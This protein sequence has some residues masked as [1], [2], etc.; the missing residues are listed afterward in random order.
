MKIQFA[1]SFFDS[2]ES[3]V[4][5]RHRWWW[6]VWDV[7]RY[8]LPNFLRNIWLFRKALWDYHWYDYRGSMQFAQTAFTD[9][10]TKVDAKGYE[11]DSTKIP[12]IVKMR[13]AAEILQHFIDDDFIELAEREYGSITLGKWNFIPSEEYPDAFELVDN[14]TEKENEH[15][16]KVFRHAHKLETEYMNELCDILRGQDAK[17]F[18]EDTLEESWKAWEDKFDGSGWRTWWD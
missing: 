5:A 6:R 9:M 3:I 16:R 11:V 2:F 14:L 15:N 4:L 13:R 7:V 12:K 18:K 17:I 10:A 8:E 1:H